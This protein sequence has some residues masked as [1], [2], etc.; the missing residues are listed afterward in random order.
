M[1]RRSKKTKKAIKAAFLNLIQE[2]PITKI[3]IAEIASSADIGRGTFYTHY[4][5]I[6]DLRSKIADES[7]EELLHIF[8]HNYP[9]DQTYDF[10]LFSTRL[11]SYVAENQNIFQFFFD[12][13]VNT[14]ISAKIKKILIQRVMDEE[15]LNSYSMKNQVEV[16]FS[17]SGIVSV[18]SEWARGNLSIS[19]EEL[20]P[21]L[22][23]II[24]RF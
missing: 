4:E 12:D 22:D 24:T 16:L 15:K 6:Y 19:Q 17:V 1:D 2:K 11:V 20:V 23:E 9:K 8:E 3:T 7:I 18:L 5:D 14:E 13:T 21:L 10:R